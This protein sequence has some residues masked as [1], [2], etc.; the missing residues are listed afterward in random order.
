MPNRY[1]SGPTYVGHIDEGRIELDVKK[2]IAEY[3]PDD[4]GFSVI[5][6]KAGKKET[7]SREFV[8]YDDPP[9]AWW[10]QAAAP[11]AAAEDTITVADVSIFVKKDTVKVAATDEVVF[12]TDIDLDTNTLTVVR[13]YADTVAADIAAGDNLLRLSTTMEE[14]SFAP[15]SKIAQPT[16]HFNY[17][18]I[19]RTTFDGSRNADTEA[20]RV[21]DSER[22]R[23]RRLKALEHRLDIERTVLFGERAEDVANRR[24]TTGG[25]M[26]FIETNM[27]D[28]NGILTEKVLLDFAEMSFAWGSPDKLLVASPRVC[29]IINQFAADRIITRSGE[30]TYG[31]KLKQLDTFHGTFYI[32][33]TKIFQYDYQDMMVAVDM[34]NV[35][36]RPYKGAD[37]K[38]KLNIHPNDFDGWMDEY[39]TEFGLE[40]RL[41]KTHAIATGIAG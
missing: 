31:L 8:W 41:E 19:I 13:G 21:G 33:P 9:G 7:G 3:M 35:K 6:M 16:K 39:L 27:F 23:I 30:E 22:N 38:L 1:Y 18:Q 2:E 24:K 25:L 29:S 20:L 12:V 11:A 17:T 37:T 4:S 40:V 32:M 28:V 15:D 10:T 5:L 36:Y 26:Y 14:G 34:K